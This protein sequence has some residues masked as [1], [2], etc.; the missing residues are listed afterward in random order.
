MR[1]I[2][3]G[4]RG[5]PL[6]VATMVRC[7]DPQMAE[8]AVGSLVEPRQF[9]M[10]GKRHSADI[11]I[12]HV[13]IGPAHLF[14][15]SHGAALTIR[16]APIGSYQ[17][18]VPLQ[19][20]LRRHGT[21]RDIMAE[22]GSALVYSPGERLFTCWSE[23]CVCLVLSVPAERLRSLAQ[24]NSPGMDTN[25]L[26]LEPLMRLHSGAGRSFANTLGMIAR[27][28]VTPDSDLR[29]GI[30]VRA[31]EQALLLSLLS[32][33]MPAGLGPTNRAPR[34]YLLRA[35]NTIERRSDEDIGLADIA[36]E[37]GVSVRTL[38]YGFVDRFGIGP[39]AYL[40]QYRLRQAYEVLRASRPGSCTIGD[41]AARWGFYHGSA[42]AHSYRKLFGELPSQTLASVD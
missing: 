19:G 16:S 28:S 42:F 3:P 9:Q 13:T 15:V 41:V 26:S 4:V 7:T 20:A 12:S 30:T 18:M 39:I 25:R 23:H 17:V 40:K 29:R 14:G 11:R 35:L 38:Q 21:R 36:R 33:Q 27:E 24:Q 8:A 6:G 32:A 31:L 34:D 22:P 37:A 2:I 10:H 5:F 1:Q